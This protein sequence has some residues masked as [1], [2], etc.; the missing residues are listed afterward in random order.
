MRT[1]YLIGLLVFGVISQNVFAEG[2]FQTGLNQPLTEA[3][4]GDGFPQYV[5]VLAIG[6][7]INVSLCGETDNDDVRIRIFDPDNI[8][9]L[10]T[11][12]LAG[13]VTCNDPFT[14]PLTNPVRHTTTKTG[15]YQIRLDN[16]AGSNTE[17]KRFDISIT[18]DA[19]TDPDPTITAGRLWAD[20][21]GFYTRSFDSSF[22]TDADYFPLVPGGRT[23]T[24]Y[25]WRLDLNQFSGNRYILS[26]NDLGANAPNSGYSVNKAGNSITPKFPIYVSYPAI[27]NARPT[28]PPVI[29]NFRFID[30][31]GQDYAITPG[32]TTP[33]VQDTGNFEFTSDADGTYSITIDTNRDGV[34]GTGDKLLL[35]VATA[36]V[37]ASVTWDGTDAA[38]ATLSPGT[39][40]AELQMR[41]GEY[42]FIADDAETS[43]GPVSDGLT[44]YM[45]NS[46]GSS[47][48]TLV[49][50]DDATLLGGTST[51]P[52]GE[53]SS[54]DAGKHAWG[55]FTGSSIGNE[56]YIDT[57]VY[58]L[59]SSASSLTA[60]SAFGCTSVRCRRQH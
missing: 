10:D 45:A 42:H 16:S 37:P 28:E 25:V 49:Y 23:N 41:L 31:V 20:Q 46:D 60:I 43:G 48:D 22:A 13:N 33:G 2:S 30:S 24:N 40:R 1:N 26:A 55:N 35:G 50:W 18:A 12:L 21:W 19:L 34:F 59:S 5:D 7:V 29:S 8:S 53:L 47:I 17:L 14:A 57:Y 44:I 56:A 52:N 27:A 9:V 4:S 38:G 6:E 58:G 11:T 51:L 54:S 32:T 15:A 3:S 36:G 39:Y